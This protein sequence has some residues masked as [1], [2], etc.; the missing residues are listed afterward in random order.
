[1]GDWDDDLDDAEDRDGSDEPMRGSVEA[2]CLTFLLETDLERKLAPDRVSS[3]VFEA[4]ARPRRVSAPGRP[5]ELVSV[6]RAP[7]TPR[8]EALEEPRARARLVHTFLHHELQ[9][10]ELFAW[11]ILSFPETPRAFR[12]GLL[13][14]CQEELSHL[15]LYRE[16]LARLGFAVGS[17]PV[18]DWFWE[19]V[20]RVESAVPFVALLGLG[21]EGANLE[22][23]ARFA[24]QFRAAGDERGAQ[25]L[26]RVELEECAHVA[27]AKHW[28]EHFTGAPLDYDR[29]RASLPAPLTP[30]LLR[31][32]PLNREARARAGMDPA[33]L[34]RLAAEPP[35]NGTRA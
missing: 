12:A 22:H 17:F 35:T 11:A 20:G 33:F 9:A 31:G 15:A 1:M 13:A 25:I 32:R 26:E 23:C 28:F 29:W 30:A 24:A 8:P 3:V 19:R 21:L 10:A 4:S 27:F 14:L 5:V 6:T 2:W 18:R 7:R 16:H 34:A